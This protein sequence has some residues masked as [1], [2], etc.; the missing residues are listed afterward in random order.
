MREA[1][2]V[3]IAMTTLENLGEG[4]GSSHR[5]RDI[6]RAVVVVTTKILEHFAFGGTAK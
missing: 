6:I 5:Y 4:S 3:V 1:V 2:V